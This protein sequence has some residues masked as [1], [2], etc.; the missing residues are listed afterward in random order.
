MEMLLPLSWFCYFIS[1]IWERG[2]QPW[3]LPICSDGQFRDVT[4]SVPATHTHHINVK[5]SLHTVKFLS[6]V[7]FS[8]VCHFF[9]AGLAAS[10]RS[11]SCASTGWSKADKEIARKTAAQ[12]RMR[13]CFISQ[14]TTIIGA[15]KTFW[16][17]LPRR[18][19]EQWWGR[20][21]TSGGPVW[22]R[23]S[24][25]NKSKTHKKREEKER[26]LGKKE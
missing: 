9:S 25:Q 1:N 23:Q 11:L 16:C 14:R 19:G 3:M 15:S 18:W 13:S 2:W 21:M 22:T 20:A 8:P 4:G 5:C 24:S 7:L 6:P 26:I 10:T 17:T 12:L